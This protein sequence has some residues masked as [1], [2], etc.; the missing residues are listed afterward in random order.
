MS[1]GFASGRNSRKTRQA[2][3]RNKVAPALIFSGTISFMHTSPGARAKKGLGMALTVTVIVL[4]ALLLYGF[5]EWLW[6][7]ATFLA[8]ALFLYL[9]W[10]WLA[11]VRWDD[12]LMSWLQQIRVPQASATVA[13]SGR[14][15]VSPRPAQESHDRFEALGKA[16]YPRPY[17]KPYLCAEDWEGHDVF[18]W[19]G[20]R[21]YVPHSDEP[22]RYL[23]V[24]EKRLQWCWPTPPNASAVPCKS[25]Q[26]N[27]WCWTDAVSY[28]NDS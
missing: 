27:G 1:N 2:S 13:P 20:R 4:L 12:T 16:T 24:T 11:Q 14:T 6:H 5:W 21:W 17:P 25:D 15:Y 22:Y 3:Q 9:A 8:L 19:K 26:G 18:L 28:R 7:I 23:C 10:P